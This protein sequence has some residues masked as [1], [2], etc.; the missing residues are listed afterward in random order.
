MSEEMK[1]QEVEEQEAHAYTV[2]PTES[3]LLSETVIESTK[4]KKQLDRLE[5]IQRKTEML[6]NA[7]CFATAA[8][9]L[10]CM[11]IFHMAIGYKPYSHTAYLLSILSRVSSYSIILFLLLSFLAK[12]RRAKLVEHELVTGDLRNLHHAISSGGNSSQLWESL[13]K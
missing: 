9:S 7:G 13:R 5:K 4:A 3:P 11:F 2:V 8:L 12:Y 6:A 10:G 1:F